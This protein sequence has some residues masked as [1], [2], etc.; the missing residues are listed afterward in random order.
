MGRW[1]FGILTIT[2][3]LA[4]PASTGQA[5]DAVR[6]KTIYIKADASTWRSKGRVSFPLVP[7]LT[8]K[9]AAAGFVVV[10]EASEPHDLVLKVTYREERAQEIRFNLYGTT[11]ICAIRLERPDGDTLLDLMIRELSPEGPSVTAPYT[12][13]VHDFETDPYYYFLGEILK[14]RVVSQLDTTGGLLAAF[15]RLTDRRDPLYG[16]ML[17]SPPN[18][19]DTLPAAEEL[20]IREVRANTMRE[21]ARLNDPR[22][23]PVL[24]KLLDHPEWRVRRNAVNA[25]AGMNATAAQNRIE[26]A[27][28][29]DPH[30]SV[31]EAAKAALS[32]LRT[33]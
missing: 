30:E 11:I 22:A 18:P 17:G 4:L 3:V 10:Q 20:Y 1:K 9:L 15:D 26:Q 31:R 29:Q 16:S 21:L 13:V 24:I 8:N 19:G 7:S 28:E 27:A 2:I 23:I 25:L 14:E 32:K 12:D 5:D 33:S 6:S